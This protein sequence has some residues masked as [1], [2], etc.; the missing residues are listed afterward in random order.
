VTLPKKYSSKIS[1]KVKYLGSS[2][3]VAK[4][5]STIKVVPKK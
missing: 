2:K 1:V 3:L 5:S 4:T